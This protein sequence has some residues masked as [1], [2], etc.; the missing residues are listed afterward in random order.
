MEK[1]IPFAD[2][3]NPRK[4]EK[5]LIKSPGEPEIYPVLL[6]CHGIDSFE[7]ISRDG[8]LSGTRIRFKNPKFWMLIESPY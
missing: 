5:I 4:G 2:G 3:Q 7:E 6:Y 1:W 8:N